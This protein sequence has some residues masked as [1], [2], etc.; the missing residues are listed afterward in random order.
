[1]SQPALSFPGQ[2]G[3]DPGPP[4]ASAHGLKAS[5]LSRKADGDACSSCDSFGDIETKRVMIRS[6]NY[7]CF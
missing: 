1:M 5:L 7:L 6:H 3:V 4:E 2:S